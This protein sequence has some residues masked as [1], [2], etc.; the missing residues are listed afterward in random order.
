MQNNAYIALR[1]I[2]ACVLLVL[3]IKVFSLFHLGLNTAVTKPYFLSVEKENQRQ[4]LQLQYDRLLER[5][6]YMGFREE[7]KKIQTSLRKVMQA[8]L[9]LAPYDWQSWKELVYLQNIENTKPEERQWTFSII[10]KTLEWNPY[11]HYALLDRCVAYSTDESMD[12]S[13]H[14]IDI[15]T[16]SLTFK[17]ISDIAN[18]LKISPSELIEAMDRLE[19]R[20]SKTK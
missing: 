15:Y 12:V 6:G 19:V 4:Q 2:G 10:K 1:L 9:N 14:C 20:V 13:A 8:K 3:S 5:Q 7:Q 16:F 18:Q 11:E 17:K